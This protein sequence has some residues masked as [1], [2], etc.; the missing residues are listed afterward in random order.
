MDSNSSSPNRACCLGCRLRCDECICSH[1]PRIHISTRVFVIVHSKEWRRTTNTGH[2][3]RLA[4]DGAAV[5]RHG[6]THRV[7]SDAGID[8]ASP[9]T[10]VLFPGR[11]AQTLNAELAASLPRPL[12]LLVPD[13]NWNQTKNMM[14]RVPMLATARPIRL[15]GPTLD[16]GGLRRNH[17]PGRMSTYEAIAQALGILEGP[18]VEAELLAFFRHYLANGV[19]IARRNARR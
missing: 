9:S 4:I 13:G 17:V 3:A 8:A 1:A 10:L 15:P 11:G 18:T 19:H 7:V 5:R 2:L 14:R 16:A 6:L 12:T